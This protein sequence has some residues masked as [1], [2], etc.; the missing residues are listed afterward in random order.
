MNFKHVG[1]PGPGRAISI[2]MR[3]AGHDI[4]LAV[5]VLRDESFN[6]CSH[7]ERLQ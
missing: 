3:T 1:E 2:T 7:R 6:V 4:E 5:G